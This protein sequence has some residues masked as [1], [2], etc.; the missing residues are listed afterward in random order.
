VATAAPVLAAAAAPMLALEVD[1][2]SALTG[3][4]CCCHSTRTRTC[5]ALYRVV[6]RDEKRDVWR[7]YLDLAKAKGMKHF[8]TALDYATVSLRKPSH[9]ERPR[10]LTR[11]DNR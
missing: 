7:W 4:Y 6:I 9:S 11:F 2:G 3:S 5:R 1:A 10:T 8:G